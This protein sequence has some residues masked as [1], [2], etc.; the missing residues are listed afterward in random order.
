MDKIHVQAPTQVV[1]LCGGK[2]S[3]IADPEPLSL[4]DA[5]LKILDKPALRRSN[6]I[7][8]EDFSIV[9][10]FDGFYQ[11]ILEF[12]TDLAQLT[13]LI[14]IFCE[15]EGSFAEFGAFSMVP[16]IAKRLLVVVRD[17]YWPSNSFISLG[18]LRFLRREYGLSSV[19]VLNDIDINMKNKVVAGVNKNVLRDVLENPIK[20][21]LEQISIREVRE[22]TTF[23]HSRAG[24]MIKLLV[25]FIQEYGALNQQQCI[26]MLG[27]LGIANS[28]EKIGA[29]LQCAVAV[30][31]I[32][33]NLRGS[34]TYTLRVTYEMPLQSQL[35]KM[36]WRKIRLGVDY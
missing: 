25:G 10:I 32:R 27:Q 6:L 3:D 30:E 15:S 12:E 22:R 28:P 11:D 20:Q 21:R 17:A 29:Y 35:K 14:L 2:C 23:D 1:M 4:R 24:H 16:E 18:P 31:W 36:L 19:F 7:R 8:A 13:E 34:T 26:E 33:K 5:F 9:E